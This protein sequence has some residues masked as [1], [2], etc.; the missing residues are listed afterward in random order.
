MSKKINP[1]KNL[2]TQISAR[3][4]SGFI[5]RM[6]IKELKKYESCYYNERPLLNGKKHYLA[7]EVEEKVLRFVEDCPEIL[8]IQDRELQ[9]IG[10]IAMALKLTKLASVALDNE[11]AS[12]QQNKWGYN[13]GM[14]CAERGFEELALKALDNH[15]ASLQQSKGVGWN[16][17]MY[18]AQQ[19]N[20][21]V[22]L[23]ALENEEASKQTCFIRKM[24]IGMHA[25]ENG[26]E[27]ATLK[28]MENT[29][30]KYMKDCN[31]WNIGMY[32]VDNDLTIAGMKSCEDKKLR[33]M[34]NHKNKTIYDFALR[35]DNHEVID[36]WCEEEYNLKDDSLKKDNENLNCTSDDMEA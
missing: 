25:A 36:K 8:T 19:G 27:I 10:H 7:D 4:K 15:K 33:H 3:K 6:A 32:A 16:I 1:V 34:K 31:G 18:A 2:I 11:I 28:A 21:V 12:I 35:K 23:K 9:N 26:L 30:T 20:E 14:Y 29:D 5:Y 13:I 24:N 17:G 22:V